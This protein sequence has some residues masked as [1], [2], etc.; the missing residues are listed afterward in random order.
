MIG[1][2]LSA[3]AQFRLGDFSGFTGAGAS[4]G[5][6][7]E[8]EGT[9]SGHTGAVPRWSP[10]HRLFT[11]AVVLAVGLGL[12]GYSTEA[13]VKGKVGPVSAGAELELE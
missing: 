6:P 5:L 3:A 9:L 7:T 10:E 11:F 2:P 1:A 13:H 4:A 12:F 8:K